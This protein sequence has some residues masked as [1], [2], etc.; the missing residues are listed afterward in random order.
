MWS[1][2]VRVGC[3][4]RET[5][6]CLIT[7]A[8]CCEGA[9]VPAVKISGGGSVTARVWLLYGQ[10]RTFLNSKNVK[11]EQL[12]LVQTTIV[13]NSDDKTFWMKIRAKE[14]LKGCDTICSNS[15][16][17]NTSC[18]KCCSLPTNKKSPS[19]AHQVIKAHQEKFLAKGEETNLPHYL[20]LDYSFGILQY[21]NSYIIFCITIL[22]TLNTSIAILLVYLPSYG[23][24]HF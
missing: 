16:L 12:Y 21:C 1:D 17:I 20:E 4:G 11:A 15:K 10:T 14:M 3:A 22:Y 18:L 2:C 19:A 23:L 7:G 8:T 6:T 24:E 5:G 13:C 9:S